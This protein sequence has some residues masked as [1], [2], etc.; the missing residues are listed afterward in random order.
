MRVELIRYPAGHELPLLLDDD[1][2]PIPSANEFI[3]GRQQ[4]KT[5]TLTRNARELMPLFE[6]LEAQQIVLWQRVNSEKGFS[7]AE[8]VGSLFVTLRRDRTHGKIKRLV[9]EPATYNHRLMTI[10]AFLRWCFNICLVGMSSEHRLR[11]RIKENQARI[12]SW[13]KEGYISAAP[14][15]RA[16]RSKSLSHQEEAFLLE[17]LDPINGKG[18]GKLTR[19]PTF[20][21][22]AT[23]AQKK[24]RKK[25]K[26][27]RL[28]QQA[29]RHRNFVAMLLMLQAGLR[30]GELLSLCVEDIVISSMSQ[31]N[32][33]VRP[34]DPNDTRRPRPEVKR[35]ARTVSMS[36][37]FARAVDE[38]ITEWRPVLLDLAEAD[39]NYL[40]LSG[41]GNPL[42]MPRLN[43]IFKELRA[44]YPDRLP[45]QLSPHA[46]RHRFTQNLERGLREVGM[47]EEERKKAL[48]I[49]RGDSSLESQNVYIEA[50]VR[51]QA[52][53]VL[54][55][56]QENTMS[57]IEDVPF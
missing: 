15:A 29:L 28:R 43:E 14:T 8:I 12:A 5:N 24:K 46:L 19:V 38:Y 2:M 6:W 44:D 22:G 17:C 53:K 36:P 48:A 35:N 57:L 13:F 40:I 32:V 34:P 9:V 10:A 18:I 26:E 39:N 25:A 45:Q 41:G 52:S 50:E 33:I 30:R 1:G 51:E 7:E 54:I 37:S 56:Y 49:M 20:D 4:L 55:R 16:S 23:P 3:L 11:E 42:S 21:K 31:V 47:E 27:S